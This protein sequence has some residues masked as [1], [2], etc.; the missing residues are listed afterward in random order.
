L[1]VFS[2]HLINFV[3]RLFG[4][5]FGQASLPTLAVEAAR[6]DSPSFSLT[7]LSVFRKIL[8]LTIPSAALLLVL[9]LPIVRIAYG[10]R[11]FSWSDTLTTA[12][13]VALFSPT[14]VA[15]SLNQLLVRGFY[16]LKDTKTPLFLGASAILVNII[17]SLG[18]TRYWQLGIAGLTAAASISSVMQTVLLL[19]WLGRRVGGFSRDKLFGPSLKVVLAGFSMAVFLWLPMRFLDRFIF[20]TTRVLP[21]LGLTIIASTIGLTVYFLLTWALEIE[22]RKAFVDFLAK[23]GNWRR[24]LAES[25]EPIGG[26][27]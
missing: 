20:D 1:F 27:K 22:E 4:A 23:V 19:I 14:V 21:L 2:Q 26:N 16:A 17:L 9:R 25:E 8:Y 18:F 13:A 5:S 24:V 3:V 6:S 10:A 7:F 15:R 12:W 11:E